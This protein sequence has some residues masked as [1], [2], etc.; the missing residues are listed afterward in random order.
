MLN[1]YTHIHLAW[2]VI[3]ALRKERWEKVALHDAAI[4]LNPFRA[5][6]T[7][8][9]ERLENRVAK[10]RL[11]RKVEEALRKLEAKPGR[12]IARI[13]YN[14]EI[15]YLINNKTGNEAIE[16]IGVTLQD[17]LNAVGQI[18]SVTSAEGDQKGQWGNH[19]AMKT[20][21]GDGSFE[22]TLTTANIG[23]VIKKL[24]EAEQKIA[25]RLFPNIDLF[26]EGN[27]SH[28]LMNRDPNWIERTARFWEVNQGR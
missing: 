18:Y 21:S 20:R 5:D 24:D 28:S 17:I 23:V 14:H 13:E 11:E 9:K 7:I 27:P 10:E 6:D 3:E 26:E 4:L 8:D 15:A 2:H 1:N 19:L 12:I 16:F 22:V 25:R